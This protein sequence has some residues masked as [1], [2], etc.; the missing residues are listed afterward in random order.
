MGER[1]RRRISFEIRIGV[2]RREGNQC[3]HCG[4]QGDVRSLQIDHVIPWS[5]GGS[6]EEWN[7]QALCPTCNSKKGNRRVG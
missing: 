6:D 7:L 3:A 4:R 1:R 5:K 2:I